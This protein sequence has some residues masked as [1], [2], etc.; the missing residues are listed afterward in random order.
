MFISFSYPWIFVIKA[1]MPGLDV[2]NFKI[3][4]FG[5]TSFFS[6]KVGNILTTSP[7]NPGSSSFPFEKD[8]I[9]D[10]N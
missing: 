8:S 6:Q 10:L 9:F 7:V 2:W 1:F 4:L 5:K 3:K